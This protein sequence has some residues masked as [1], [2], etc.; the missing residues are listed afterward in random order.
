MEVPLL[1]NPCVAVNNARGLFFIA[2]DEP[3][4]VADPDP[5]PVAVWC[6]VDRMRVD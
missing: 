6:E 1:K 3:V 2:A 4:T 5:D